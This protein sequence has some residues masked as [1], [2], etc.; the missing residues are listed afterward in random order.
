MSERSAPA[1][2]FDS[3]DFLDSSR[4]EVFARHRVPRSARVAVLSGRLLGLILA[5]LRW[6]DAGVLTG[7]FGRL[8]EEDGNHDSQQTAH[9]LKNTSASFEILP[10][11]R[12]EAMSAL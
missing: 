6:W 5:G 3:R 8:F 10:S 12:N 2:S 9:P 7:H 4:L 11:F 1:T